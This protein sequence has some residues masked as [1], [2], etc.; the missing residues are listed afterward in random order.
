MARDSMVLF[1]SMADA[2]RKLEPLDFYC[3]MYMLID[4]AMDDIEPEPVDATLEALWMAFK[5]LIDANKRRYDAQVENGKKGGRPK[6]VTIGFENKNPTKPNKTQINPNKP[7]KTQTNQSK[8]LNDK[9]EMI[10]DL[11]NTSSSCACAREEETFHLPD[12]V[13]AKIMAKMHRG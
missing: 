10:N 5:P 9:C 2:L 3:V 11:Y 8:T 13:Y 12:D 6:K 7:N 1:R 4:Y